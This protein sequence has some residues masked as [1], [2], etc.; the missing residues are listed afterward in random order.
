MKKV[1][2]TLVIIPILQSCATKTYGR[3][4]Q[5]TDFEKTTMTCR[6]IELDIA[7]ANGF[8]EQVNKESSFSG[9]DVLAILGDFGIGNNMER[10]AAI[11][12]AND[13]IDH[14]REIQRSKCRE[15][16]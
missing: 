13:R 16:N 10:S 8:I 3:Q 1:I 6:E 11:S 7:K 5:L 9:R 4:S 12:S 14:L 2:L 15:I